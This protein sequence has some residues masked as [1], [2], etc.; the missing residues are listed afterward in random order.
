MDRYCHRAVK[1]SKALKIHVTQPT[2]WLVAI[3][4]L[5]RLASLSRLPLCTASPQCVAIQPASINHVSIRERLVLDMFLPVTLL[6]IDPVPDGGI[7]KLKERMLLG[8]S[9]TVQDSHR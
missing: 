5:R 1:Q 9:Q 6:E 2:D 4:C 3:F 7:G 8:V